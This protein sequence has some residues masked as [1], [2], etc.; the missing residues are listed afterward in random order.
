MANVNADLLYSPGGGLITKARELLVL[1]TGEVPIIIR[2]MN[3][4]E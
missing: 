1:A 4:W 3:A 2:D